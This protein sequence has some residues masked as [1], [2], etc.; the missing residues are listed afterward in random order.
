MRELFVF[1]FFIFLSGGVVMAG[2]F[3]S[4]SVPP[5][6]L[7]N[8]RLVSAWT[9]AA[10]GGLVAVIN[11]SRTVYDRGFDSAVAL[12]TIPPI[13]IASF[14]G[15]FTTQ[16]AAANIAEGNPSPLMGMI[17]G[18]FWGAVD[19][20]IIAFSAYLPL[21][22]IGSLTGCMSF[23]FDGGNYALNLIGTTLMG[24]LAYGGLYGAAFGA[25]GGAGIGFYF[26]L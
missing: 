23:N 17:K 18:L 3:S 12:S 19:G 24:S 21:F 2:D 9:G 22:V 7:D 6:K 25:A 11:L 26:S 14:V 5:D 20:V 8:L 16:W 4:D 13:F 1:T 15:Y 10:A